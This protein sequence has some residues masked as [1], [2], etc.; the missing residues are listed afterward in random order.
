MN[1]TLREACIGIGSNRTPAVNILA[2]L[3]A[4]SRQFGE[5]EVSAAYESV[6]FDGGGTVYV[7]LAASFATA[8]N[9]S[10]LRAQLKSIEDQCGRVRH[11]HSD[12]GVTLDLDLLILGA[13]AGDLDV[14]C[15]LPLPQLYHMSH[16]LAP[17]AELRPH[18]RHPQ[19]L[20]SLS[21]MRER[22]KASAPPVHRIETGYEPA[23]AEAGL[24]VTS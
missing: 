13:A 16:V 9:W 20:A 18:W 10:Q 4:L 17:M 15:D 8:L 2:G 23:C 21:E 5:V 22:S 11:A 19:A 24:P 12:A 7:N 14:Q 6:D 1:V 3:A